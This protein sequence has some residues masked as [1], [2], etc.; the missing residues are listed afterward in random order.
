[1]TPSKEKM[2]SNSL[3]LVLPFRY[4]VEMVPQQSHR[5]SDFFGR[6]NYKTL[7]EHQRFNE[8]AFTTRI[9]TV[10]SAFEYSKIELG[11]VDYIV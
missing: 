11:E 1:M 9:C 2:T 8:F 6:R 10:D 4:S 3:G 7:H 5:L